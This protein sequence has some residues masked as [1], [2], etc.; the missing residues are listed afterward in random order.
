MCHDYRFIRML[1]LVVLVVVFALLGAGPAYA[2][3]Y[4]D[5]R[6]ERPP[7]GYEGD[8]RVAGHRGIRVR[9]SLVPLKHR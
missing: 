7:S 8:L 3:L 6:Y 5:T 2:D 4:A 1:S 9:V